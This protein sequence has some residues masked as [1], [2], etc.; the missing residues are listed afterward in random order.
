M[1]ICYMCNEKNTMYT[2]QYINRLPNITIYITDARLAPRKFFLADFHV[3]YA[4]RIRELVLCNMKCSCL[5]LQMKRF[6]FVHSSVAVPLFVM[7]PALLSQLSQE[8]TISS[9]RKVYLLQP[10]NEVYQA[11]W[12]YSYRKSTDHQGTEIISGKLRTGMKVPREAKY[13]RFRQ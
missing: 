6:D 10:R 3:Q 7:T 1:H 11:E 13:T 9:R 4:Y 2:V 12:S 8:L 5:S